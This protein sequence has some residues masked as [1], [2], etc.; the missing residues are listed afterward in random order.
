[1]LVLDDYLSTSYDPD[2]EYVDGELIERNWGEADHAALHAMISSLFYD[3]R[4]KLGIH[5]FLSLR[6]QVAPSRWL[7]LS[8]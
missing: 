7:A 8:G 6:V 5:V 3:Q 2:R 4:L 1:M